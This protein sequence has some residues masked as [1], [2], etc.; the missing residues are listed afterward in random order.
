LQIADEALSNIYACGDVANTGVRNPNS[1]SAYAQ[2]RIVADNIALAAR[3]KEPRLE[4]DAHWADRVIKLTLGLDKSVTHFENGKTELLFPAKETDPALMCDDA[5]K[6]LGAI[7]FED[8]DL[9]PWLS[10]APKLEV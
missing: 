9:P 4:Y 10:E 1:R 7:P 5:W 3:G 6:T 8:N 2:A